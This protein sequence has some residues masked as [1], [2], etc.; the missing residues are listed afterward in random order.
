MS[1]P[2]GRKPP[3]I[4]QSLRRDEASQMDVD[5]R[6]ADYAQAERE[7]RAVDIPGPP[8]IAALLEQITYGQEQLL[9]LQRDQTRL[10]QAILQAVSSQGA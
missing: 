8:R 3:K 4:P 2:P 5:Q 10:L 7:R 6:L 1:R 9:D